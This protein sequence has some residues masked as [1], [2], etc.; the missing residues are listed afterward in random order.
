MKKHSLRF[1][2]TLIMLG[3]MVIMIIL[4]HV[5]YSYFTNEYSERLLEMNA[6]ITVQLAGNIQDQYGAL[7][8]ALDSFS[9]D[10]T[11]NRFLS[12]DSGYEKLTLMPMYESLLQSYKK[13]NPSLY[14]IVLK[15]RDGSIFSDPTGSSAINIA[16]TAPAFRELERAGAEENCLILSGAGA[17]I[18]IRRDIYQNGEIRKKIGSSLFVIDAAV[19]TRYLKTLDIEN[20]ETLILYR[21][22]TVMAGNGALPTGTRLPESYAEYLPDSSG[23]EKQTVDREFIAVSQTVPDSGFTVLCIT[24]KDVVF[25]EMNG[26]RLTTFLLLG[27]MLLLVSGM[28]LIQWISLSKAFRRFLAHIDAIA[29]GGKVPPL[30]LHSFL[31]FEQLSEAFNR[32]IQQLE[33]LNANNLEYHEKLLL[34]DLE[35]K[36]SQLLALQSQINPHFLYNTLECINSAGAVCGSRDVEDMSTALAFIFRYA[37]KGGHVVRLRDELETLRAYISIQQ[38]RFPDMF[39]ILY[40]IPSELEECRMLKFLLQ[41]IAENSILHG[42]RNQKGPFLIRVIARREG[43]ALI[44]FVEDNGEGIPAEELVR[45]RQRLSNPE[46]DQESIG[47]MN[48]QRRIRLYYGTDFGLEVESEASKGTRIT[49]RL[50]LQEEETEKGGAHV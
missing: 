29:G 45:L 44:I 25:S 40:E 5:L 48:I 17:Y 27:L 35:N 26:I 4:G 37:I 19:M 32:M 11:V 33:E 12:S 50:P 23:V 49:A 31:E 2:M 39:R 18:A 9:V 21:D 13:M 16:H 43:Q 8:E 22:G 28:Y 3:M 20:H 38:I 42:F 36:Q 30:R 6:N 10:T 7:R 24:G 47:L 1:Q 15:R 14:S 46:E 34:Q 41:P